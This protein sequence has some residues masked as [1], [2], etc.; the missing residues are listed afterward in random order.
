MV[1]WKAL[2]LYPSPVVRW[3]ITCRSS[4]LLLRIVGNDSKHSLRA[5]GARGTPLDRTT[6]LRASKQE[7]P[8]RIV[9][10]FIF[11]FIL[12]NEGRSLSCCAKGHNDS[13]WVPSSSGEEAEEA[14][15]S[16]GDASTPPLGPVKRN[17]WRARVHVLEGILKK[18]P[19]WRSQ[20]SK[21]TSGNGAGEDPG[22]PADKLSLCWRWKTFETYTDHQKY[23]DT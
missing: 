20:R 4:W 21:R 14:D 11:L 23:L 18:N 12:K 5:R 16:P 19:W 13:L 15:E 8:G 3:C 22:P 6:F 1:A 10:P 7:R 9:P 2:S 17:Q